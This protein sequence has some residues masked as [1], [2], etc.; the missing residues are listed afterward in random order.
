[1]KRKVLISGGSGLLGTRMSSLLSDKG[2]EV[3]HLSRSQQSGGYPTLQWDVINQKLDS[4]DLEGFHSI[5][6]LSGA[7]IVD[8]PWTDKRK[9]VII[10]SRVDST[11]LLFNKLKQVKNKP[12]SVICASAIGYY[13][14]KTSEHIYSEKDSPGD[15]FLAESC[16]LWEKAIDQLNLLNIPVSKIRIGIVLSNKGGALEKMAKPV[17]LGLGAGLGNGNQYMPWIHIDDLCK[18]FIHC[19]EKELSITVNGVS[20]EQVTNR[21]FMSILAKTLKRPFWLP[22]IPAV[23]LK[24]VLGK[25]AQLVLEGSRIAHEKQVEIGFNLS[26]KKLSDALDDLYS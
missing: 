24:L 17:K 10:S 8:E 5:M 23:V 2:Y 13:G 9:K 7:G 16:I 25:R 6:H 3:W 18:L 26:F 22:N 15:G 21:K 20:K 1:M 12:R 11:N 19:M 14:M 4:T